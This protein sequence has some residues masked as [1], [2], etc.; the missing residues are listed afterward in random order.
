MER[1]YDRWLL[2]FCDDRHFKV[3]DDHL[4]ARLAKVA[5]RVDAWL[6]A[7]CGP[8]KTLIH[9]DFK[10]GNLFVETATRTCAAIDWQWAG[11]GC[12][13]HDVV[14]FFS[15]TA[16]D[17]FVANYHDGL[18]LYH[19]ALVQ[20]LE[21]DLRTKRKWPYPETQRLFMLATLDYMRWC[22]SYRLV[23]ETPK[24]MRARAKH[25]PKDPNQGEYRRSF[26]RLKYLCDLTELFLPLAESGDL[27]E[28]QEDVV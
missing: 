19:F 27:G 15:T 18:W 4:G 10:A 5:T 9:G 23:N 14:Y 20:E 12:G 17:D 21:P 26:R 2:A 7:A 1:G 13:L 6:G 24:A 8:R 11:W 22:W 28:S 3:P 25:V 16:A